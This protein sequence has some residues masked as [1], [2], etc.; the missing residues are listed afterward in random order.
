M[1]AAGA[2]Q[3][4]TN[5]FAAAAQ[6]RYELRHLLPRVLNF[7]WSVH[8]LS[9]WLHSAHGAFS[10]GHIDPDTEHGHSFFPDKILQCLRT[11]LLR[12]NLVRDTH[13]A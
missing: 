12:F 4:D 11:G 8:D 9:P 13:A 7:K 3:N 5:L 1:V 2:F 6:Q 10:F